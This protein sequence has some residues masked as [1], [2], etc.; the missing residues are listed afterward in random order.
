MTFRALLID[1][2]VT[3]AAKP[4]WRQHDVTHCASTWRSWTPRCPELGHLASGAGTRMHP[5]PRALPLQSIPGAHLTQFAEPAPTCGA[6]G[7]FAAS[8]SYKYPCSEYLCTNDLLRIFPGGVPQGEPLGQRMC[9]L[10]SAL[11]RVSRRFSGNPESIHR[12]TIYAGLVHAA[13]RALG[14]SSLFV[15]SCFILFYFFFFLIY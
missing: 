9:T 1:T 5:R 15:W 14:P 3:D 8:C 10:P 12:D 4:A 13:L 7:P 6:F 11:S 2:A